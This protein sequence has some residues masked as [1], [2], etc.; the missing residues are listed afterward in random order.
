MK[1]ITTY[2]PTFFGYIISV[3]AMVQELTALICMLWQLGW[4]VLED[5]VSLRDPEDSIFL[6]ATSSSNMRLA[7]DFLA[8]ELNF[9]Y[10]IKRLYGILEIQPRRIKKYLNSSNFAKHTFLTLVPPSSYSLNLRSSCQ[11]LA[12]HLSFYM[13]YL[14]RHL[15]DVLINKLNFSEKYTSQKPGSFREGL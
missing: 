6:I 11:K 12:E 9:Q 8:K 3:L 15:K 10:N 5:E 14:D 2:A 1:S 13:K 4:F 7:L